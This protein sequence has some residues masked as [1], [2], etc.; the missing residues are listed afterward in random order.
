MATAKSYDY[1][2]VGAGSAGCVLAN[3]LSEDGDATVL[4]IESGG[5]DRHPLIHVP[6]GFG[7]IHQKHLFD[8]GYH[9]EPEP[10]LNNRRI[11]VARGKI[12][13]GCSSINFTTYTR[14]HP[15]DYDR[16][17]GNGAAGWSYAEVLP[18]FK[19]GETFVGGANTWRGDAGPLRVEWARTK[20]PLFQA[21]MDAARNVGIPI[22][23]DYNGASYEGFGRSQYTI[24]HG[25]R[26]SSAVAY[27]RPALKRTNLSVAVKAHVT[28][29]TMRGTTATGV[30]Y[31]SGGQ[32]ISVEAKR[33]V[34][35]AAGTVNSP[36][37]LM[38]AGI[39]PAAHLR[40]V[41]IQPIVD[42]PV[43]T[44]LQD[45]LAAF[46]M[47]AR[48]GHG[49]FRD[50]MRFDNMARGMLQAYFFGSG[51]ATVLPGGLHAFVKLRPES[52][53][54]D[55]EF[56]FRGAPLHAH[57][58]FPGIKAAY[59]DGYGIRPALLHPKSRGNILLRSAD[60][61]DPVRI[62]FNFFSE[63]DD[64]VTLKEGFRLA[65]HVANQQA[66][67]D[68]RKGEKIPGPAI[69]G[70]AAIEDYIRRTAL[71]AHH[72]VGT[73]PMGD[74]ERSVVDSELKVRGIERLRVVDASVMPDIVSAHTNA[75]TLMIAE[76]ASDL[77]RGKR[78]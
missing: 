32:S 70:D 30:S 51:P 78:A 35:L 50:T 39:G 38:L 16:W 1:V 5:W 13:G 29:L 72:P 46:L 19:R 37:I 73:C 24:G 41:G 76:K 34:V 12:V 53:V 60:P 65:R 43:G 21:W 14:G 47:F 4:L 40:D 69:D 55:I 23:E 45:H 74:D 62:H 3:R 22:T 7:K 75:A 25:R 26:S 9:S 61:L 56:M 44:N 63:P 77:I 31:V 68:F 2:I 52:K 42:L 58:W 20:D 11:E 18:Y 28:G 71:T 67:D 27:L 54:P 48:K 17:A 33:E 36:Q 59:E 15:G 8:W 64:M 57:L 10:N 6:I 66:L 49:T